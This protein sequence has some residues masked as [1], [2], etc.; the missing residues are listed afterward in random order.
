MIGRE[1]IIGVA[2]TAGTLGGTG[3][4]VYSTQTLPL[5]LKEEHYHQGHYR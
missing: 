3:I 4:G 1:D 2:G 5:S